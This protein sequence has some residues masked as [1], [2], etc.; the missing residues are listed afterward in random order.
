[1]EEMDLAA[2]TMFAEL[3]QRT[4]DAEFDAEFQE[5]GRFKRK[6]SNGR[7]YWHYQRFEG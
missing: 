4:L 2:Q 6:K 1:M 3:L 5:N 7:L